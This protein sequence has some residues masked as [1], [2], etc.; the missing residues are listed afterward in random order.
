MK[1][2]RDL[3]VTQ[4]TAWFVLHRLCT[5][6]ADPGLEELAG[7]VE[8]DESFIGG[9]RKNMR[10]IK[11]KRLNGHGGVKDRQDN[12]VIASRWQTQTVLPGS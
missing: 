10:R 1:L 3:G 6:W 2:H 9:N 11:H 12:K 7:L 4:K 5:A 8:V